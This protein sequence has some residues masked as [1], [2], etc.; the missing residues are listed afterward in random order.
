[1]ADM[2]KGKFYPKLAN[3]SKCSKSEEHLMIAI[4]SPVLKIPLIGKW[5]HNLSEDHLYA[6]CFY[7]GSIY[8][9][10]HKEWVIQ[11]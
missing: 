3:I 2:V 6:K 9:L 8:C 1:M 10:Y 4:E 5:L 7:C 11:K